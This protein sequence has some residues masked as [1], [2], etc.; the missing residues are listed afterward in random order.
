VQYVDDGA[1]EF[2]HGLYGWFE[3]DDVSVVGER[4]MKNGTG[5]STDGKGPVWEDIMGL[6]DDVVEG[7]MGRVEC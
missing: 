2:C 7:D 3:N 1:D 6:V 5:A 4:L